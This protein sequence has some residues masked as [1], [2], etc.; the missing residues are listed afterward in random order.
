MRKTRT[1]RDSERLWLLLVAT[2]LAFVAVILLSL[3]IP[4]PR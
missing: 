1:T 4:L 3:L 2:I